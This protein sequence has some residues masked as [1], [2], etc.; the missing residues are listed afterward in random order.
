[1][2]ARIS[3]KMGQHQMTY[4]VLIVEDE[5]ITAFGLALNVSEAGYVPLGPCQN[6][7][8]VKRLCSNVVP[9]LALLDVHLGNN[10][11]GEDVCA[12]L[13]KKYRTTCVFV[14]GNP[15]RLLRGGEGALGSVSKPYS[16]REIPAL[17]RYMESVRFNQQTDCPRFLSLF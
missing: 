1:M 13:H 16:P 5:A 14:T 17:L 11:S 12:Y 10:E 3:E 8:Q 4:T 9:D 2:G 6:L 15:Y 7:E